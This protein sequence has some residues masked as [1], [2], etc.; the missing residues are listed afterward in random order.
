MRFRLLLSTTVPLGFRV[1]ELP[2]SP[3]AGGW[4][5]SL[6]ETEER[7]RAFAESQLR[8]P[9]EGLVGEVV[10]R[11]LFE[12]RLLSVGVLETDGVEWYRPVGR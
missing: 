7:A 12:E 11:V 4:T 2:A 6:H 1:V 3:N 9:A 5:E 10:A 8:H